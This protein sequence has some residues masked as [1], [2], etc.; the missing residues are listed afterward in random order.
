MEVPWPSTGELQVTLDEI[1]IFKNWLTMHQAKFFSFQRLRK[2]DGEIAGLIA[3][4][5]AFEVE[6]DLVAE[7]VVRLHDQLLETKAVLTGE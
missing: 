7:E 2:S 1:R 3:W 4:I 6:V 5:D